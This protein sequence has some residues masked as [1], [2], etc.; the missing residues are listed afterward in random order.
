LTDDRA[1]WRLGL[2]AAFAVLWACADAKPLSRPP[3][4]EAIAQVTIPEAH[5]KSFLLRNAYGTSTVLQDVHVLGRDAGCK[6]I[7]DA[8]NAAAAKHSAGFRRAVVQAH[9]KEV[10]PAELA[11]AAQGSVD[12][13]DRIFRP[14]RDRIWREVGRLDQVQA[15]ADKE[16]LA[17]VSAKTAQTPRRSLASEREMRELRYATIG[18]ELCPD[19]KPIYEVENS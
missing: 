17:A 9:R 4:D 5:F 18:G 6:A 1:C 10:P 2:V 16:V 3:T 15:I 19:L 14:Y 13:A 7:G 11:D 8:V 12:R